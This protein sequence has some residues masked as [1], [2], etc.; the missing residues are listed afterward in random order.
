MW[1][2]LSKISK[3]IKLTEAKTWAWYLS[4]KSSKDRINFIIKESS[5][6][7]T[8]VLQSLPKACLVCL[9]SGKVNWCNPNIK[10]FFFLFD[11]GVCYAC[12]V[13]DC[14]KPAKYEGLEVPSLPSWHWAGLVLLLHRICWS[15]S[16]KAL[17]ICLCASHGMYELS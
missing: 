12:F 15:L 7:Q 5:R 4:R 3:H 17:P 13:V 14:I 11:W 16:Q 9:V 1:F 2:S 8:D 6:K 10:I